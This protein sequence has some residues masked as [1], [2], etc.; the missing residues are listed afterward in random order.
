MTQQ[1]LNENGMNCIFFSCEL[2][3]CVVQWMRRW[4]WVN[5]G[6]FLLVLWKRSFCRLRLSRTSR[7]SYLLCVNCWRNKQLDSTA[8]PIT[9]VSSHNTWVPICPHK[10]QTHITTGKTFISVFYRF[11]ISHVVTHRWSCNTFS[12]NSLK[13][14]I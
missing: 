7:P 10:H 8:H 14:F 5:R 3:C 4:M 2:F 12:F 1:L 6:R 9:S 13:S 11:S